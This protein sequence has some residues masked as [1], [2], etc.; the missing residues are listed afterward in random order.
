VP[1]CRIMTAS[2]PPH[3]V[4]RIGQRPMMRLYCGRVAGGDTRRSARIN[5]L[6]DPQKRHSVCRP[7]FQW[8]VLSEKCFLDSAGDSW[9]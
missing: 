9:R 1:R 4:A 6:Y 7:S 8:T 5:G 2:V 3:P